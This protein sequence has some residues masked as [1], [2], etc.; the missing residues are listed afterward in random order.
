MGVP[1]N[2]EGRQG[3]M[4]LAVKGVRNGVIQGESEDAV[5]GKE[6]EIISWSWGMNQHMAPGGGLTQK[7]GRRS[8]QELKITKSL[9]TASTGLLSALSSNELLTSVVL[10][11]RKAGSTPLEFLKITLK[12]ACVSSISVEG[13][14]PAGSVGL[15]EVVTFAFNVIEV[16]YI[17][18][19]RDGQRLGSYA[20]NDE[21]TPTGSFDNR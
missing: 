19:G 6:I 2:G 4:F 9:D 21:F 3:D 7:T 1:V 16:E 13:G 18:Q 14:V 11:M 17:G 20:W 5:H 10:T 8:T 15:V 12:E